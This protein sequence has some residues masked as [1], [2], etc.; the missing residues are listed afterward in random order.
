MTKINFQ[1]LP[2]TTTPVNADNLND[3]QDNV[4]TAI[5][6]KQN[7][8][9]SGLILSNAMTT[10][11]EEGAKKIYNLIFTKTYSTAPVVLVAYYNN[12]PA[13]LGNI[14]VSVGSITTTGCRL[15]MDYNI[16]NS[17]VGVS[18]IVIGD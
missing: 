17:S 6:T 7:T 3:L 8:V 11:S 12:N 2:N 18:Y 1:N 16:S 9:E 4:E 13:T 5:N 14:N 10:V 15:Q